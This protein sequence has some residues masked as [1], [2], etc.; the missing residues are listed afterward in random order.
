MLPEEARETQAKK[1][2]DRLINIAKS[3]PFQSLLIN[4]QEYKYETRWEKTKDWR[5]SKI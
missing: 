2:T 4:S 5:K 3:L 1:F